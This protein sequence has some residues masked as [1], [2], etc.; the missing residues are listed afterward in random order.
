MTAPARR[1]RS[2]PP[3]CGFTRRSAQSTTESSGWRW[4]YG[5]ARPQ[6]IPS[7]P[8][9]ILPDAASRIRQRPWAE[10]EAIGR[11]PRQLCRTR[12]NVSSIRLDWIKG[13]RV[14]AAP[15]PQRY[16][17]FSFSP[18]RWRTGHRLIGRAALADCILFHERL[19]DD[20]DFRSGHSKLLGETSSCHAGLPVDRGL[21]F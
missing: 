3:I 6:S 20:V 15:V 13:A 7:S 16:L 14:I 11:P 17:I 19:A 10:G 5:P 8:R 18:K 4:S 12:G 1:R 9:A 2:P 21:H